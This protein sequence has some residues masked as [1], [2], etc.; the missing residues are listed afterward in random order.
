MR[1]KQ[2]HPH[3]DLRRE[4]VFV[5]VGHDVRFRLEDLDELIANGNV[6]PLR[7]RKRAKPGR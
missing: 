6:R 4:I 5:R 7:G 1:L 2:N 3:L